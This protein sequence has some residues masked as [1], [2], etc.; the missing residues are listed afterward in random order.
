MTTL[1]KEN[2]RLRAENQHLR[3]ILDHCRQQL[4]RQSLAMGELVDKVRELEAAKPSDG[5]VSGGMKVALPPPAAV[6]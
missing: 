6:M 5:P 4:S 2:E 1:Q 3:S